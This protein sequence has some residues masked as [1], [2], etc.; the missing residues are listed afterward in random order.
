[1]AKLP[2]KLN[3]NSIKSHTISCKRLS[4]HSQHGFNSINKNIW[5]KKDA[6][7]SEGGF[8][9]KLAIN[10]LEAEEQ[11]LQLPFEENA[12][13]EVQTKSKSSHILPWKLP[14]LIGFL[15]FVDTFDLRSAAATETDNLFP[16][17]L[18]DA[19]LVFEILSTFKDK[20]VI[21]SIQLRIGIFKQ[22]LS[23]LNDSPKFK[24][25]CSGKRVSNPKTMTGYILQT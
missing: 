5:H 6:S 23:D 3:F 11:I 1:M 19:F 24:H 15:N 4:V 14:A 21:G 13:I 20:L 25:R 17:P 12:P 8:V 10:F 7:S 2:K 22:V 16:T 9:S 18:Y